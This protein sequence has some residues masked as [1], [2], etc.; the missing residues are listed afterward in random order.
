MLFCGEVLVVLPPLLPKPSEVVH[1]PPPSRSIFSSEGELHDFTLQTHRISSHHA[2]SITAIML[3]K[4]VPSP[5]IR[6]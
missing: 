2:P 3:K 6:C 1:G 4:Y 5:R